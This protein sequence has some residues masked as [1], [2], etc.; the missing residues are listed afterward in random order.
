MLVEEQWLGPAMMYVMSKGSPHSVS[1]VCYSLAFLCVLLPTPFPTLP[2]STVRPLKAC[3]TWFL[4]IWPG[5]SCD[6]ELERR[7]CA[8]R[9]VNL[10]KVL[11]GVALR[12]AWT[13]QTT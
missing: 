2:Q 5:R 3:L 1:V 6:L 4:G 9:I 12:M 8:L 10:P 7:D 13:V 11:D